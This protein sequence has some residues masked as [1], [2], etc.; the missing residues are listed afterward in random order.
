[1]TTREWFADS[2]RDWR[3]SKGLTV[4]Q[5]ARRVGV[6]PY[7]WEGWESGRKIPRPYYLKNLIDFGIY[8]PVPFHGRLEWR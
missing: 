4:E 1:M 7:T 5:A 3:E 2:L 8:I 6:K